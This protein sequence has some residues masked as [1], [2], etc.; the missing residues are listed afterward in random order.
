MTSPSST[1]ST[2]T[3]RPPTRWSP[4]RSGAWLNASPCISGRYPT[5]GPEI[6]VAAGIPVLDQVG[7]EVFGALKDGA[8]VRLDGDT[9]YAGEQVVAEGR[10]Q[11]T[12]GVSA[13]LLEAKAGLSAQLEAFAANTVEY[14]KQERTLLLDGVGV[15]EWRS[16]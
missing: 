12:E 16:D 6:L 4:R 3:G 7:T 15:P 9:L 11:T 14:M 13:Q 10:P 8:K 1:R 5:L 2:W